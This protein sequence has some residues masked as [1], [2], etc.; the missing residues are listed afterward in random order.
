MFYFIFFAIVIIFFGCA[1]VLI[2]RLNFPQKKFKPKLLDKDAPEDY[3][4]AHII[5]TEE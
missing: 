5:E 1:V 3:L 4:G 2:D